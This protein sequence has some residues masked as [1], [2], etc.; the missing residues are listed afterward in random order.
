MTIELVTRTV[1]SVRLVGPARLDVDRVEGLRV[2]L[3]VEGSGRLSATEVEA[4]NLS[5]G[6]AGSG[7]L[8]VAGAAETLT[9]D[10]QGTGDLDAARLRAANATITTATTGTVAAHALRSATVTAVGLGEVTILGSPACTVR[11]IHAGLVR[12]GSDQSQQR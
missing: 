7:R 8:E 11:G 2:D 6:V 4:D 1:R 5:P 10:V 12:C 9:A 3:I